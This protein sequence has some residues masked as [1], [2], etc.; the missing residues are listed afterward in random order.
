MEGGRVDDGA[1]VKG[2]CKMFSHKFWAWMIKL[3]LFP[4]RLIISTFYYA[5]Q[6]VWFYIAKGGLAWLT[7]H[8]CQSLHLWKG[9]LAQKRLFIFN[10]LDMEL[11]APSVSIPFQSWCRGKLTDGGA[12]DD[13]GSPGGK[14]SPPIP[15]SSL[16]HPNGLNCQVEPVYRSKWI[17]S[18]CSRG[19]L[20]GTGQPLFGTLTQ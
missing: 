3:Y 6:P 4:V 11:W 20:Q 12:E 15:M 5:K 14:L 2:K 9:G 10:S 13:P 19:A 8:T 17:P 16:Q 1:N 7:S 18:C